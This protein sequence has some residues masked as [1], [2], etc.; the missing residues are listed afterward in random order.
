[1]GPFNDCQKKIFLGSELFVHGTD[2]DAGPAGDG[3]D[4]GPRKTLGG[5]FGFYCFASIKSILVDKNGSKMEANWF[6][7][8]RRKFRLCTDLTTHIYSL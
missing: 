5:E 6:P 7:F 1:M 4:N 8:T 2:T 3:I